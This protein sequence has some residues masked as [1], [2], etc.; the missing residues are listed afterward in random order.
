MLARLQAIVAAEP[1]IARILLLRAVYSGPE[2]VIVVAKVHPAE[3]LPIVQLTRAMD[4][5]DHRIRRELPV[6]ADVFI[7]FTASGKEASG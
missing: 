6:V 3:N 5:L 2:E 4:E 1:A 7:D